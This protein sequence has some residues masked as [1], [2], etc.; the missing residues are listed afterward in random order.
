MWYIKKEK[1]SLPGDV[2]RSKTPLLN[3]LI[4]ISCFLSN[5]SWLA[6]NSII[7]AL[8]WTNISFPWYRHRPLP[9]NT[10]TVSWSLPVFSFFFLCV[11]FFA[12]LQGL[13]L[14]LVTE[15]KAFTFLSRATLWKRLKYFASCRL[16]QNNTF[17]FIG[18]LSM[19]T[20]TK[21][22]TTSLTTCFVVRFIVGVATPWD[23]DS[24]GSVANA[25]KL[26][27]VGEVAERIREGPGANQQTSPRF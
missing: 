24:K 20:K 4:T 22:W 23:S 21:R 26:P 6:G 13:R 3:L 9:T 16:N 8:L 12:S 15:V 2:R 18:F 7:T 27:L 5:D 19:W 1:S 14:L 17:S 25:S 11:C 10:D